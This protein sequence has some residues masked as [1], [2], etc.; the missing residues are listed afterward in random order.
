MGWLSFFFNGMVFGFKKKKLFVIWVWDDMFL[1]SNGKG[2]KGT[3]FGHGTQSHEGFDS[4]DVPIF[5]WLQGSLAFGF[6]G[7]STRQL[8]SSAAMIHYWWAIFLSDLISRVTRRI[9][10]FMGLFRSGSTNRQVQ[11]VCS[12]DVS[13]VLA[14]NVEFQ[15][16][17]KNVLIDM[18][19]STFRIKTMCFLLSCLL[20]LFADFPHW[21]V[22][23]LTFTSSFTF[24][25]EI[26]EAT[27]RSRAPL[28]SA[29]R[30][31]SQPSNKNTKW[32][33][34]GFPGKAKTCFQIFLGNCCLFFAVT[35]IYIYI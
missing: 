28:V 6:L 16:L 8:P 19:F 22:K 2:Y 31:K 26:S 30:Q 24:A 32:L 12:P 4:D 9:L 35:H 15:P 20:L 5:S 11:P 25:E 7:I 13:F 33:G 3:I 18:H 34:K 17:N 21:F 10:T 14:V 23:T 1:N 29:Q 27:T